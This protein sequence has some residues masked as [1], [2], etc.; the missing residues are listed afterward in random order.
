MYRGLLKLVLGLTHGVENGNKFY[1]IKGFLLVFKKKMK[2]QNFSFSFKI[3]ILFEA[4]KKDLLQF[5]NGRPLFLPY[6]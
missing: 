3:K 1:F 6:P 4:P 2:S 5:L